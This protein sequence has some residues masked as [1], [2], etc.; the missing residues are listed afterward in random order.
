MEF[1]ASVSGL[2]LFVAIAVSFSRRLM[3]NRTEVVYAKSRVRSVEG[4]ERYIRGRA[5]R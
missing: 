4:M 3:G 2:I 1:I 5:K